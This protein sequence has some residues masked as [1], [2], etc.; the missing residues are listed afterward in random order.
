MAA[1]IG[2]RMF[3]WDRDYDDLVHGNRTNTKAGVYPEMS[4]SDDVTSHLGRVALVA[5]LI[6]AAFIALF[7]SKSGTASGSALA[8][9]VISPFAGADGM[10]HMA[11][12]VGLRAYSDPEFRHFMAGIAAISDADVVTYARQTKADLVHAA[13]GLG[14]DALNDVLTLLQ[15]EMDRRGL[16]VFNTLP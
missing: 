16:A 10:D 7:P 4:G 6:C 9:A 13:N 1:C 5:A 2:G 12:P 11:M 8:F 15:L 14:V 3:D